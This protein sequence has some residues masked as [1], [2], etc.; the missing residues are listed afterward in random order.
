MFWRSQL[1]GLRQASQALKENWILSGALVCSCAAEELISWAFCSLHFQP[2]SFFL[3]FV[4]ANFVSP[5]HV[6]SSGGFCSSPIRMQIR[7]LHGDSTQRHP[8]T[9]SSWVPV[10]L[11]AAGGGQVWALWVRRFCLFFI[12]EKQD[13]ISFA[14]QALIF[15][16]LTFHHLLKNWMQHF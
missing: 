2:L 15:K 9:I 14:F 4:K 12:P 13:Y 7:I 1:R 10:W 3:S 16:F 8:P 6:W 5:L 11:T